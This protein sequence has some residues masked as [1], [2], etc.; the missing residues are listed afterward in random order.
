MIPDQ[1][2][3]V[4]GKCFREGKQA[5]TGL[6]GNRVIV[7]VDVTMRS[8]PASCATVPI[9]LALQS[10]DEVAAPCGRIGKAA[11]PPRSMTSASALMLLMG[12]VAG[13]DAEKRPVFLR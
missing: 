10:V 4:F 9:G 12:M 2:E 6:G 11:L 8:R 1:L 3:S 13:I 7:S 5:H